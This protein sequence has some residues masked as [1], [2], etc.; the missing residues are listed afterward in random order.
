MRTAACVLVGSLALA[1]GCTMAVVDEGDEL[2]AKELGAVDMGFEDVELEDCGAHPRFEL[3]A[4]AELVDYPAAEELKRW[5]DDHRPAVVVDVPE[6]GKGG[7][8]P[9]LAQEAND[10]WLEAY[11]HLDDCSLPGHTCR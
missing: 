8:E 3:Q 11:P 1:T 4:F 10:A 5:D 6:P 7:H 2:G 9:S